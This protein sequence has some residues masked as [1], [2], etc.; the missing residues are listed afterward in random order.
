MSNAARLFATIATR[1]DETGVTFSS[2]NVGFEDHQC[3]CA[4]TDSSLI[5]HRHSGLVLDPAMEHFRSL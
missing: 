3:V 2:W 5:R 1:P 4:A